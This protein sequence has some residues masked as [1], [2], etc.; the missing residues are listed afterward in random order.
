MLWDRQK[1][2]CTT[3]VP[4]NTLPRNGLAQQALGPSAAWEPALVQD[5]STLPTG[6]SAKRTLC[7]GKSQHWPSLLPP[8]AVHSAL[9]RVPGCPPLSGTCWHPAQPP[10]VIRPAG[11]LHQ[12]RSRHPQTPAA[13]VVCKGAGKAWSQAPSV[14]AVPDCPVSAEGRP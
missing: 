6:T 1:A 9:S 2:R 3:D 5:Q 13:Y 10:L 8:P 4:A 14:G 7:H 12:N 11:I